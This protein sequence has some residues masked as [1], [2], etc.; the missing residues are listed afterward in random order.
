MDEKVPIVV[1]KI[2]WQ[3]LTQMKEPGD[4]FDD[5]LRRLLGLENGQEEKEE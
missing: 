4:S 2:V 5:V 1:S 3:K